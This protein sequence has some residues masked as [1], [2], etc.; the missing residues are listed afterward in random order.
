MTGA[1]S[2][3]GA[4]TAILFSKHGAYVTMVGRNET[5]L[6]IVAEK[7]AKVGKNP[8]VIVADLAKEDDV[9]TII[10]E[11]IAKYGKLD[12]LVNNAGKAVIGGIVNGKILEA[13][14]E[15]MRVNMRAV[16]QLTC[17]AVPYLIDSKGCIVNISSVA[18]KRVKLPEH[19][20]YNISKAGLDIF[21]KAAALELSAYGVRVNEISPGPVKTDFLD[22]ADMELSWDDFEKRMPLGRVSKAEEIAELILYLSSEKAV[23]ITGSDFVSD[24]GALLNW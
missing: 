13:Y 9:K 18:G 20:A 17:L 23:G 3:I 14:D 5:K 7:C 11:T 22:N 1:S 6:K 19:A 10:T 15:I 4:A 21:T 8:L 12:V 24:N 2:G 16:I